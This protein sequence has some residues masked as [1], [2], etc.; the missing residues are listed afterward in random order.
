MVTREIAPYQAR[1]RARMRRSPAEVVVVVSI[2]P[3]SGPGS[4]F[5]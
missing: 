4:T 3:A 2:P 5:S 1:I